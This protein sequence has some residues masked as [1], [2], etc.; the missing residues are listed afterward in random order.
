VLVGIDAAITANHH[1][2]VRQVGTD[3]AVTTSRFLVAPT[4]AGLS[5]LTRQLAA[6]PGVVA[7][8]E[9]T[10]MTW[11]PLVVALER[12]GGE[13]C[14]VGSR[15]AARLRGAISAKNK[16]DVID[17][18][19]LA[20][21]GEVFDLA[22][23][24]LP[25]PAQLALRRVATRRAAAVIDANRHLRRLISLA[26]WAVPD[27]WNGFGGSLPT[28]KAVLERWPHLQ[29]LANARRSALTA[30]VAEHTRGV[31]DVP[32][33]VERIR[34]AAGAWAAFWEGRLD[35]DALGWDVAEHLGD[36][37]AATARVER[38]TG[39]A[40]LFWERLFGEDPL[41]LSLPGMGPVTAP[42]VRAFLGDASGFPTAKAAASYVG[43][44]PSNWSSGTVTQPSRAISKEGPAALRLAFYQAANAARHG[45]PQ[46]A[47]FYHRLM[48]ER[49]HC[50]TQATVAVAR[51]L[52]ERTWTVLTEG[53]AYQLCD[54]DGRPITERAAKAF[55]AERFT[56]AADVRARARAHSAAT[57]RA[58]LTR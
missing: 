2:C 50:H 46:L 14:L 57:H 56:V 42:T 43:I 36:L 5:L 38:A 8:A 22:P 13:L 51:K 33:R 23:V 32:A 6:Y 25:D 17:A 11:L 7:V 4:L 20:R 15:H 12:A 47:A 41:L 26:R 48:T 18:D 1:V 29:A 34:A 39:Q 19:V 54:L 27:V 40:V 16:S 31:G 9:P 52:V 21:A 44:T 24:R 45:D 58:K 28:A 53:R 30:V 3:G 55:V 37:A 49:G 10:S 35:L